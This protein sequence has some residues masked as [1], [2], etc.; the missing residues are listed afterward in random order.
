MRKNSRP[1]QR[2]IYRFPNHSLV[3]EGLASFK[4]SV[5]RLLLFSRYHQNMYTQLLFYIISGRSQCQLDGAENNLLMV[6]H[7]LL[8]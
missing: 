1:T 3:Q 8:D 2:G 6:Y 4:R 7:S 5:S